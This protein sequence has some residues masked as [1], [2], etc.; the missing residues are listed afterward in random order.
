MRYKDFCLAVL[1]SFDTR[2]REGVGETDIKVCP[3]LPSV[4]Q[5]LLHLYLQ[6]YLK[7][8]LG[9]CCSI[10]KDLCMWIQSPLLLQIRVF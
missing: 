5:G 4:R 9:H 3:P 6:R 2:I 10:Q 7:G 8:I 1:I